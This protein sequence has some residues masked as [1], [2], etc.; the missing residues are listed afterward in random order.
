VGSL[1]GEA[2]RIDVPSPQPNRQT[3]S[4]DKKNRSNTSQ[5]DEAIE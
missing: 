5:D 1:G 4:N 2:M 3:H